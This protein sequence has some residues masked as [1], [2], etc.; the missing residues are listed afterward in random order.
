MALHANGAVR[1][2]AVNPAGTTLYLAGSFT[3]LGAAVRY[4]VASV[5]IASRS[6]TAW[7]PNNHASGWG[8]PSRPTARPPT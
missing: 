2:L 5:A 3:S 8:W 6:L 7:N 4:N 1:D